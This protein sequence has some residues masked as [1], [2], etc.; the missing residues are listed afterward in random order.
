MPVFWLIMLAAMLGLVT[1]LWLKEALAVMALTERLARR[2]RD[3]DRL[4][5]LLLLLLRADEGRAGTKR[6]HEP[7]PAREE[8]TYRWMA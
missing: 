5:G 8:R 3:I 6:A 1:M 7:E 2:D 4:D